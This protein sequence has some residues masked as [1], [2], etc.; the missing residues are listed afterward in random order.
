[1]V[2][3]PD[4]EPDVFGA[5]S[6]PARRR[7]LDLLVEADRSVNTIAGHFQMSRP[8]V[9]QHLRIPLDAGLVTE[10][11]MA[12]S[13]AIASSPRGSVR[14]GTGWRTMSGSGMNTSSDSRII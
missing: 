11:G 2:V 8:A 14:C 5:I 12:E 9:S 10:S 6:H 1:M 13:G 7:M 3:S 4:R